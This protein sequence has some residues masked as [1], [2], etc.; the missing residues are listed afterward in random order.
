M[1]P[2][3]TQTSRSRP[4][5]GSRAAAQEASFT[6][7]AVVTLLFYFA[8]HVFSVVFVLYAVVVLVLR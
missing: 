2:R 1:K 4:A 7:L 3:N 6:L 5:S 8:H